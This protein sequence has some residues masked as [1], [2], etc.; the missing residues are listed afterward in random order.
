MSYGTAPLQDD[1]DT[2]YSATCLEMIPTPESCPQKNTRSAT[3]AG[4]KDLYTIM[5]LILAALGVRLYSLQFF[6]VIATDGTSY[7]LT[8]RALAGGDFHGIGTYGLYP[9]L[10][11]VTNLFISDLETAGR[12]TSIITG[13]LLVVPLYLL[14]KAVFSRKVA[15]AAALL[16]VVWPCLVN[17][18]CEVITQSTHT[19]LQ[20]T[21]VL[22]LWRAFTKP[23]LLNGTLAGF[24]MGLTF[25]T[26]PE[27]I[28]LFVVMPLALGVYHYRHLRSQLGLIAAYCGGFLLLFSVNLLLVH[29]ISGHWQ[30]S[31]KTDSAL[32]D[33]L[34]YYLNITDMSYVPGFKP[35]GYLDILRDH[36]AFIWVNS[37]K[38]LK[39]T[40]S[41]LLPP[42]LWLLFTIGVFSG[43][44]DR[45]KN[46][47]R[48]FL[49]SSFTP[50]GV[51]IT[52]YYINS[53]YVEAYMPIMFL[54]AAAGFTTIEEK[55]KIKSA[56]VLSAAQQQL[57]RRTPLLLVAVLIYA[58]TVFVPQI[59]ADISDAE[60]IPESDN[61]RRAEKHIG[62]LLKESLPPGKIMTRW[63]RIAFYAERDYV[64][65]PAETELAG[66]I[67]LARENGVRFF[68]ADG[69]LYSNRPKLGTEI[70][71]PLV[72]LN[73][74]PGRF[75]NTDPNYRVQ[76]LRPFLLY[77][78]PKSIGV[79]VYE[80]EPQPS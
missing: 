73:Q 78:D 5:A 56:A 19:T 75:F 59:H 12:I 14:G 23:S 18:S 52:F 60:Y 21:A 48:L 28:A 77:T 43:G 53:G 20:L 50:I 65:I 42:G 57:L 35:K 46:T 13:S 17:S 71:D 55:L 58:T 70:F 33:A 25:L 1:T 67:Q 38:N 24:F 22:L 40:W 64:N 30:L 49:L 6:H 4:N 68:I 69:V 66:V 41:T 10:I 51:L 32:N 54:F 31:A 36:P 37:L 62:L 8:A 3:S 61:Y 74:P 2:V 44:F 79:V 34:S 26:R 15:I 16:S 7:A 80:L 27:G 9:V 39:A 47:I 45:D 76:G 11:A 29:H 72:G 63:A